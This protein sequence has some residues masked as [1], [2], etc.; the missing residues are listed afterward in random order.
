M[1]KLIN[2]RNKPHKDKSR[3]MILRTGRKNHIFLMPGHMALD[4]Q[5]CVKI[6]T[7][8]DKTKM[9]F[10]ER[11]KNIY[12][13][14]QKAIKK[15]LPANYQE[16]KANNCSLDKIT[17]SSPIDMAWIDLFGNLTYSECFW[18]KDVLLPALMPGAEVAFT[19]ASFYRGNEVI[20][21]CIEEEDKESPVFAKY[22]KFAR[23]EFV[24]NTE[25][26]TAQLILLKYL[27]SGYSYEPEMIDYP[28]ENERGQI[29]NR[30]VVYALRNIQHNG[31][32]VHKDIS[33]ALDHIF[34]IWEGSSGG[35][36][37]L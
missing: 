13:L 18:V 14:Q 17:F 19:F 4:V 30:Y 24:G 1:K 22:N 12:K 35:Y 3:D 28:S 10:C 29:K 32:E 21:R 9:T 5:K 34:Y 26:I 7:I 37:L 33:K 31:K 15:I 8:D 6:G 2:W 25:A 27:F 23:E 36:C 11:D 16:P 20:T